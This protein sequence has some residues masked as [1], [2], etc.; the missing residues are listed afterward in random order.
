M[1]KNNFEQY[2]NINCN[3]NIRNNFKSESLSEL[4]LHINTLIK[5]F[6]DLLIIYRIPKESL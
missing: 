6:P 2:T 4:D 5:Y 1:Y 3:T